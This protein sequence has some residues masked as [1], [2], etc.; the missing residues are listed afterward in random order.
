MRQVPRAIGDRPILPGAAGPPFVIPAKA[1]IQ[2]GGEEWG[3]PL[4]P[5]EANPP[6]RERPGPPFVIP[7]KA[8]IQRGG[9]EYGKASRASEAKPVSQ[10]RP[11]LH[12]SFRRRPESRRGGGIGQ[13]GPSFNPAPKLPPP[14]RPTQLQR[15]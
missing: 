5:S 14:V 7:A 12:S 3:G 10:Q 2:R 9:G 8:G 15:N 4:G 13:G 11:A 6:S 1:G